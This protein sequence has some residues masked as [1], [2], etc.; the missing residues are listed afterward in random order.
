[1]FAGGNVSSGSDKIYANAVTIYG[2]ATASVVDVF[3]KDF[4]SVGGDGVGGL[5]GDGN[6]T[7]VDGYRELNITNYGTDFYNLDAD[8]TYAEYL[9]LSDREKGF[10]NLL[11][12]PKIEISFDFEG[13]HYNYH[14]KQGE[15]AADEI[16]EHEFK[17]MLNAYIQKCAL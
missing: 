7:F 17:T 9:L 14:T 8:L 10:Y 16:D 4:I 12:S 11:Y 2:N 3:A 1:M 15:T 5:Y 13:V 6:L